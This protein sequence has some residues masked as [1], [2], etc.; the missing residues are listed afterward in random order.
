[1]LIKPRV[2]DS[3]AL[4]SKVAIPKEY[5]A[6]LNNIG[7]HHKETAMHCINVATLTKG[8]LQHIGES[9]EDIKKGY[10]AALVH[11]AGKLDIPKELLN[12][13]GKL[14]AEE[15][16]QLKDHT[17]NAANYLGDIKDQFTIFTAT[18]HH[19]D[20]E[21]LPYLTRC[22]QICDTYEALTGNRSYRDPATMREAIHTMLHNPRQNNLDRKLVMEFALYVNEQEILAEKDAIKG[23]LKQLGFNLNEPGI[24]LIQN[25]VDKAIVDI[26]DFKLFPG[27]WYGLDTETNELVVTSGLENEN[28]IK[29]YR[30]SEHIFGWMQSWEDERELNIIACNF[31]QPTIEEKCE[32]SAFIDY[33]IGSDESKRMTIDELES[34]YFDYLYEKLPMF[35]RENMDNS[36]LVP[37]L[38]SNEDLKLSCR[39]LRE[40]LLE[41]KYN[42]L[43]CHEKIDVINHD[44]LAEYD[45]NNELNDI[46]IGA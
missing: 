22:I 39:S 21:S 24:Y 32:Y 17:S 4:K 38:I 31:R 1:M 29:L 45:Y 40:E 20:S 23:Q 35:A 27:Y 28:N 14:T 11:D 9:E 37:E 8:F 13:T 34:K 16:E 41:S 25:Q 2:I 3:A 19:K 6:V 46:E 33:Y 26:N 42:D 30:S 12:K 44:F 15:R 5:E 10:L 7:E 43:S 18:N 36:L